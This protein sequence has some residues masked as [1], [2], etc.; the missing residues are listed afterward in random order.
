MHKRVLGLFD[1]ED[2]LRNELAK[3]LQLVEQGLKLVAKNY[4]VRNYNG[5][6]GSF[7]ILAK[8]RYGGF[9]I[10]E[11]KRSDAA[12][13]QALHELSKYIALFMDDQKVDPH[14]IR[15]FILSTHWHELDVPLSY[16]RSSIP[17]EVT[18]F[19][20]SAPSGILRVIERTLPPIDMLP[21]LCPDAR[22]LYFISQEKLSASR[23][24]LKGIVNH[25]NKI[26]AALLILDDTDRDLADRAKA[27]LC[28]W[29]IKDSDL[30]DVSDI[31]GNTYVDD[32]SSYYKGW[33]AETAALNWLVDQSGHDSPE[34][35]E[36]TLATPEKIAAILEHRSFIELI[37]L[38]DWPHQD[39]VNDVQEI[40]RCLVAQDVSP[41]D[42]RSNL[43]MFQAI[44][45]PKTGKSWKYTISAFKSYIGF[46]DFWRT[47]TD[48]YLDEINCDYDVEFFAQD[49]KHFQFR[50]YQHIHNSN[51]D[52]SQFKIT[53]KDELGETKGILIGGWA[54]DNKTCPPDAIQQLQNAYGSVD[55]SKA[56]L[57]SGVDSQRYEENY[58]AHGFYPYVVRLNCEKKNP[59]GQIILT[60]EHPRDFDIE[61]GLSNFIEN[62]PIYC[63]KIAEIMSEIP[64]APGKGGVVMILA[65]G[66]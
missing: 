7:D 22:F 57:F 10:I 15:C 40:T 47:E 51:A 49:C 45:N 2:D 30:K 21:K 39:L 16:F 61:N 32:N 34:Y 13:R 23:E 27:V 29:R 50:V 19:E 26:R 52:L 38:G 6:S 44:S 65:N 24:R 18:G 59:T 36:P 31:L 54:W 60:N 56:I 3:K 41:V 55:F 66:Y 62:N 35:V 12:A 11:V 17:V 20:V 58:Y 25:S 33:S 5:A 37:K 8:D 43:H 9:V 53:L 14:K 28:I 4:P 42:R 46:I 64:P 63:K 48:R 1:N